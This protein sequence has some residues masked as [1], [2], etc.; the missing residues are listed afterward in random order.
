[1]VEAE[2][3]GYKRALAERKQTTEQA[4]PSKG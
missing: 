4:K 1:L 2:E 3:R